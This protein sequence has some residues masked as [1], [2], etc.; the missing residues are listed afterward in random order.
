MKRMTNRQSLNWVNIPIQHMVLLDVDWNKT[1]M[2][3]SHSYVSLNFYWWSMKGDK[4]RRKKNH[5]N[6][7]VCLVYNFQSNNLTSHIQDDLLITSTYEFT[8]NTSS[9][10]H[11]KFIKWRNCKGLIN[12]HFNIIH[13][14]ILSCATFMR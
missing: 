8:R 9:T 6:R 14:E 1:N 7:P 5:L 13:K 10:I 3:F 4:T 12:F 11:H 2:R